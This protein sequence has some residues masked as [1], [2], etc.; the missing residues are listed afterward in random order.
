M[1]Q[2]AGAT[3]KI[4]FIDTPPSV[5]RARLAER[6]AALPPHNFYVDPETLGVFL[7]LFETPSEQE[8]AQL[9]VVR[10]GAEDGGSRS[11]DN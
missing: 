8:G 3:A 4:H 10:P 6:N 2:A 7:N 5:I 9:V 1:A 11:P